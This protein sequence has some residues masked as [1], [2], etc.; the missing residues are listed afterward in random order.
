MWVSQGFQYTTLLSS[1]ARMLEQNK[2]VAAFLTA[3]SKAFDCTNH[4]LLIAKLEA[5]GFGHES[6]TFIVTYQVEG[7]EQR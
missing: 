5:Y 7:K 1:N 6:L 2:L 4:E 3:L